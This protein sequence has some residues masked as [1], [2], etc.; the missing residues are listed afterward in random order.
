M[1]K[2][3]E[4]LRQESAQRS[5]DRVA[6]SWRQS[7]TT[8][9]DGTPQ[10][11]EARLSETGRVLTV[12]RSG[13]SPAHLELTVEAE[14]ARRELIAAQHHL[15]TDFLDDGARAFKG[16]RRV[17]GDG[18][19]MMNSHR[20]PSP[21]DGEEREF[22]HNHVKDTGPGVEAACPDCGQPFEPDPSG[23]P[24]QSCEDCWD[25]YN[26]D[27]SHIPPSVGYGK[28]GPTDP[29]DAVQNHGDYDGRHRQGR[30]VAGPD[31]LDMSSHGG[32]TGS[33]ASMR[34]RD[35]KRNN[36]YTIQRI[37]DATHDGP[38]RA[39]L[40]HDATQL[41]SADGQ[42]HWASR[43]TAFGD[44]YGLYDEN[45][46]HV[47]PKWPAD[48]AHHLTN[49]S[50]H[51]GYD[52]GYDA[53]WHSDFSSHPHPWEAAET[54]WD[55]AGGHRL[56]GGPRG[57]MDGFGDGWVDAASEIPHQFK[58]PQGYAEYFAQQNGGH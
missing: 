54:A 33:S 43:R 55:E 25:G 48:L 44:D 23:G 39:I 9:F 5:L 50:P 35:D 3:S 2:S 32:D 8:W 13:Y 20:E 53:S 17:A 49:G 24:D 28:H 31:M 16:S 12:A 38:Q 14:N 47:G 36:R 30:R 40:N 51:A 1:F 4:K 18:D 26:A 52:A 34:H 11:I 45:G 41:M 22:W 56:P 10:S 7:R 21:Y 15:M 6:S 42:H 29:Y 58:D 57:S 27:N 46:E 19:P 37:P